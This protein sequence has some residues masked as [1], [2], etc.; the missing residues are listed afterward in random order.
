MSRSFN[1]LISVCILC[2]I[3][4]YNRKVAQPTGAVAPATLVDALQSFDSPSEAKS[5]LDPKLLPWRIFGK[6]QPQSPSDNRPPFSELNVRVSGYALLGQKGDLELRFFNDRLMEVRFL[7]PDMK[8][9]LTALRD[10]EHLDLILQNEVM[11]GA[12][13]R[14]WLWATPDGDHSFVGWAD[15]RLQK[16]VED[17]IR[18]YA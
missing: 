18:R 2:A 6:P 16:E 3:V 17:W 4:A 10:Q 14:V 7:P 11:S 9:F 5:K 15:I 13:V 8:G 12:Y 1:T